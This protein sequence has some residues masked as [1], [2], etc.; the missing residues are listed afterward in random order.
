MANRGLYLWAAL[1]VVRAFQAAG[2]RRSICGMNDLIRG[3]LLWLGF[4]DPVKTMEAIRANDPNRLARAAV[5]A[6]IGNAYGFG[7]GASRSAAEMIA[8][9]KDKLLSKPGRSGKAKTPIVTSGPLAEDLRSAIATYTNDRQDGKYLGNR[10]GVDRGGIAGGLRLP[11]EYNSH[12]KV[13]AWYVE[14]I[15]PSSE[16]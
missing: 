16:P 9:A 15:N 7:P 13:N 4:A 3:A 5:F 10:F 11:S 6:A 1:T 8:D 2:C 12:K 14:K